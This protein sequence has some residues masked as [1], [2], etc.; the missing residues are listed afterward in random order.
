MRQSIQLLTVLLTAVSSSLFGNGGGYATG[1]VSESGTVTGFTPSGTEKVQITD[2]TLTIRLGQSAAD[3]EV[4][5]TLKNQGE[6]GEVRFGFPVEE[7]DEFDEMTEEEKPKPR[8]SPKYCRDYSVTVNGKEIGNK[9][10]SETEFAKER[11]EQRVGL[12]GWLISKVNFKAN[13]EKTMIIRYKSDYP[14]AG[15]SVSDDER[16]KAGIFRYRL[17]T[18]AAWAGPIARGR[19]TI[20]PIGIFPEEVTVLKPVNQFKRAGEGWIWEFT[21]LEPTLADDIEV[22]AVP[23]YESYGYRRLD[24]SGE[25]KEGERKVTFIERKGT[26]SVSHRNYAVKASSTL[27]PNGDKTYGPENLVSEETKVW[28]EGAKGPGVGEWLEFT[29]EVAQPL[30]SIGIVPGYVDYEKEDL[31]QKNARPR[32]VEVL[33]NDEHRFEVELQDKGE[34]QEIPVIGYD[35]PVK[36]VRLTVKSVYPGAK[37]EDMCITSVTL[38]ARLKKKP[39][40]SP[41]R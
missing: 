14:R 6:G 40:V 7:L 13:E 33:L 31:F 22:E 21:D 9:F 16:E 1:G 37:Y 26:W 27:P 34:F 35:T 2:E 29:P 25:Y 39:E 18:G 4:H 32:K 8:S 20:E 3:V 17:S 10:E 19:I 41:A 5:Y 28:C 11:D 24:G 36:T 12:K 30:R 38:E 23:A 15:Y